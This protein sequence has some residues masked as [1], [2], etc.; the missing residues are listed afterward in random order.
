MAEAPDWL[1]AGDFDGDGN[2]DL[3]FASRGSAALHILP[4]NGAGGFRAPGQRDLPGAITAMAG[5]TLDSRSEGL[6]IAV[7]IL[8][9]RGA[10]LLML[11]S[12]RIVRGGRPAGSR[13]GPGRHEAR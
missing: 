2:A 3:V 4:G 10:S 1:F 7:A 9:R 12:S 11:D 5:G 13:D 8:G 6:G